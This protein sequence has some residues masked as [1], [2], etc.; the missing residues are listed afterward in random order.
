M[1]TYF[2]CDYII[3][4]PLKSVTFV[5]G[6]IRVCAMGFIVEDFIIINVF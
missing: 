4:Q 3:R 5:T 6:S 2:L 1:E